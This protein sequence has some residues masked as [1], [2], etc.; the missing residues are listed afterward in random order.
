MVFSSIEAEDNLL[1][2]SSE[3][4]VKKNI[5]ALLSPPD[6]DAGSWLWCAA[7]IPT[8][9]LHCQLKSRHPLQLRKGA[10][11]RHLLT[12]RGSRTTL[13]TTTIPTTFGQAI[14]H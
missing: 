8:V 5:I 2:F 1:F 14:S 7:H 3:R 9:D 13:T 4:I 10:E 6:V 11:Q 12:D